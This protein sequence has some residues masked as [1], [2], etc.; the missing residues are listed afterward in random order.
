MAKAEAAAPAA[1]VAL[2]EKVVATIPGVQRKGAMLP[3][4]SLNGNMFSQLTKS[5]S[6][7]LR[8][9]EDERDAFLSK[10]KTTL[11]VQYGVVQKEYVLVPDSLLARTAELKPYFAISYAY[12]KSLRPKPTTRPEKVAAAKPKRPAKRSA[13]R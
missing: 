3:Y 13:K 5:G 11:V 9:P 12:A 10:Y 6:M 7:A 1:K 8:L 2:Y 4:T